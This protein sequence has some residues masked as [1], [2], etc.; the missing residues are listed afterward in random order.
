MN[1]DE[2]FKTV[3]NEIKKYEVK[4]K[5]LTV[6]EIREMQNNPMQRDKREELYNAFFCYDENENIIGYN[7]QLRLKENDVYKYRFYLPII[8]ETWKGVKKPED[9][10]DKKVK[11]G[12]DGEFQSQNEILKRNDIKLGQAMFLDFKV[13]GVTYL[14]EGFIGINNTE[15]LYSVVRGLKFAGYPINDATKKMNEEKLF[16]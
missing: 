9:L 13:Q 11:I 8:D 6:E 12:F 14:G 15:T 16:V 4:Q 1:Y 7:I 2:I 10:P 5:P 3:E